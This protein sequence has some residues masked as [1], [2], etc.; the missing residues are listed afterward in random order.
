MATIQTDARLFG[1]D[2]STLWPDLKTAAAGMW[3]WPVLAWLTPSEPVCLIQPQGQRVLVRHGHAPKP[4]K[5]ADLKS[6][7]FYAVELPEDIVLR[8]RLSLPALPPAA[9]R[10]ALELEVQRLSPFAADATLWTYMYVPAKAAVAAKEAAPAATPAAPETAAAAVP[11][12]AVPAIPAIAAT[13]ASWHVAI[14]S[15]PLVQ[16][17]IALCSEHCPPAALPALEVWM[18]MPLGKEHSGTTHIPVAGFGEAV[19]RSRQT[20]GRWINIALLAVVCA[21]VAALAITPTLQL[22][23]RAIDAVERY[24]ALAQEAAPAQHQ[25]EVMVQTHNQLQ[26]LVKVAGQPTSVLRILNALTRS[27]PDD[28]F[29]QSIQMDAADANAAAPQVSL[30]GQTSNA[31]A[32]MQHLGGQ[33]GVQN[34]KAPSPAMRPLGAPKETFNIQLTIDLAALDGAASP[35]QPTPAQP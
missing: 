29:L 15:R 35:K 7:R 9:L 13:P 25:R 31:A 12:D 34:V 23:L 24:T 33:P 28:T 1:L 21:L 22:R 4:C 14:T 10:S 5:A 20:A 8:H 6:V 17:H 11:V 3:Q 2:L 16:A 32:L 27:I 30:V 18:P 19:R 26:Q